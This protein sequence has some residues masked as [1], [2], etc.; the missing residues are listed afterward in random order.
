MG[1]L[2]KCI[3][4]QGLRA[5]LCFLSVN[6]SC[7]PQDHSL[8]AFCAEPLLQQGSTAVGTLLQQLLE[9]EQGK[10]PRV[11][12]LT[13]HKRL[14]VHESHLEEQREEFPGQQGQGLACS[15]LALKDLTRAE[16]HKCVHGAGLGR[17]PPAGGGVLIR[18]TLGQKQATPS[19]SYQWYKAHQGI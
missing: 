12:Q 11:H 9:A 4:A 18:Q 15:W 19:P 2:D 6:P 3:P 8:H 17:Q 5:S 1:P 14:F 10:G 16:E 7:Q 13:Q